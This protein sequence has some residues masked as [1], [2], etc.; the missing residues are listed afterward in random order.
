MRIKS[1]RVNE[2]QTAQDFQK[3][4]PIPAIRCRRIIRDTGRVIGDLHLDGETA[5][6]LGCSHLGVLA[7]NC[8]QSAGLIDRFRELSMSTLPGQIVIALS[9]STLADEYFAAIGPSNARKRNE[10]WN[11]GCLTFTTPE[12]LRLIGRSELDDRPVLAIGLVDPPCF[13]HQARGGTKSGFQFNDRPQHI[14]KF[15]AAHQVHDWMPP[16]F[17]FTERP[18]KALNTNQML[19]AYSLEG[20]Q[21]IDG[22]G[23]RMGTPPRIEPSENEETLV[24]EVVVTEL[25]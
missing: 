18:A 17:L 4:Y 22:C 3:L 6:Q 5:F 19:S 8:P 23:L 9:I 11:S 2:V 15:R 21:F 25:L 1:R 13:L 12:K 7:G 14:A 20:W 24:N 10:W 16:F